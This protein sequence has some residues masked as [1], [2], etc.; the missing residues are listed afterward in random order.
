MH[1]TCV[2]SR[3]KAKMPAQLL[4]AGFK[5][6]LT[7]EFD[8]EYLDTSAEYA[9]G[10]EGLPFYM[11]VCLALVNSPEICRLPRRFRQ[12][13]PYFQLCGRQRP[14]LHPRRR[15]KADG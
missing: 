7:G 11:P 13:Q 14:P 5:R 12:M 15:E 2:K 3:D 6:K 1:F 9:I 8:A 10:A 4:E